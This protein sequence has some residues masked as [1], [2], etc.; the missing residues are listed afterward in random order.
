MGLCFWDGYELVMPLHI[1]THRS[2]NYMFTLNL[3]IVISIVIYIPDVVTHKNSILP[4]SSLWSLTVYIVYVMG[5][6]QGFPYYV[7]FIKTT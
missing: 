1:A 7:S 2:Y 4:H 5:Q 3:F 6:P